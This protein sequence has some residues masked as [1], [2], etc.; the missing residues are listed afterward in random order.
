MIELG[1]Y[2]QT[3]LGIVLIGSF[4]CSK[5]SLI[6]KIEIL[7]PNITQPSYL[8]VYVLINELMNTS[9]YHINLQFMKYISACFDFRDELLTKKFNW[10]VIKF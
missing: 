6:R 8:Y 7:I 1:I 5:Y 3:M 10:P 4:N 2:N 9:N